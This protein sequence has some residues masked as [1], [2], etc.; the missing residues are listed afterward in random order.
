MPE[1]NLV[2]VHVAHLEPVSLQVSEGELLCISGESGSGK[3]LLLRAIAD[4][5]PH[6]GSVSLGDKPALSMS[7]PQW[8]REVGLLPAESQW[9]ADS[10]N[11]HFATER[12]EYIKELGLKE[13]AM[14]WQISRCSTGEKQRLALLRLLANQ[15][16][17][18]L[19][20]EPTGSLD[21]QNTQ[22]VEQLITALCKEKKLPVIWVSHSMEQIQRIA[23]RHAVMCNGKL[24]EQ[25]VEK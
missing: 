10:V 20:D 15:P 18:L 11:S 3:S 17:C 8:R 6:E 14:N 5:I 7:G 16:A 9:W 4:I 13:D 1:L 23:D 21:P 24:T 25:G 19:L 22:R 2:D 12:P